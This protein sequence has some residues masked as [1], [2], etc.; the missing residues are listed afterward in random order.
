MQILTPRLKELTGMLYVCLS[1][2]ESW[3]P[4]MSACYW[5]FS[6]HTDAASRIWGS[7]FMMAVINIILHFL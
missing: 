3:L 2:K 1:E 7:W 6:L 5:K 4:C